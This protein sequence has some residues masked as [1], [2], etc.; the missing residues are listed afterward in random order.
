VNGEEKSLTLYELARRGIQHYKEMKAKKEAAKLNKEQ[1]DI[2]ALRKQVEELK[3]EKGMA[4]EKQRL[5]DE[6][7]VLQKE[8]AE[9]KIAEVVE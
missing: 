9:K 5:L 4:E 8:L 3:T 6:I 1:D 2:N 7:V